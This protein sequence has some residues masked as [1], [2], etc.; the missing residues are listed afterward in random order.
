MADEDQPQEQEKELDPQDAAAAAAVAALAALIA[1]DVTAALAVEDDERRVSLLTALA[2]QSFTLAYEQAG[3]TGSSAEEGRAYTF[4]MRP[5]FGLL[6][7]DG[8]EAQ[9]ER[10]TD[11][12]AH[13]ATTAATMAAANDNAAP[14]EDVAFE[15]RTMQDDRVRDMH[16]PVHGQV[17]AAGE[18]FDVG[19]HSLRYPGQPVGPPEAWINCRCY[20][21]ATVAKTALAAAAPEEHTG[22]AMVAKPANPELIA[23]EGGLPEDE[24]H[25]TLGYFGK[26]DDPNLDPNLRASLEQYLADYPMEPHTARVGGVAFMGD[27]DPQACC[28]LLESEQL[29][30]MRAA[31]ENNYAQPDQKHPHFTPHMTLGYGMDMPEDRPTEIDLDHTEL[32]WGGERMSA[33]DGELVARAF[34]TAQRKGMAD[35]GTAMPDGSYPIAN[36]EDLRNAIQAIGRAK[37]PDAVKRH[38]RKRAAALGAENLIPESWTASGEDLTAADTHDAPGWITNP[39]ETQRLR[40]YWTK[41]AGAAKIRW[42][43][44]GD[45]TRCSKFLG[46]YVGPQ[47]AWGTCNNLHYEVFGK[48]NPEGGRHGSADLDEINAS[49]TAAFAAAKQ[50]ETMPDEITAPPTEWFQDPGFDA[51]TPLTITSDGRVLGHLAAWETCHVGISGDCVTPPKSNTNYAHFRTGEVVTADGS[52]VPVGQI[53]MDTGHAGPN[54]GP[55]DT[56]AHYDNTGTGVADVA[57]GEDDHGIWVAGAM[58]PGVSEQQTYA[59]KA[60]G[61]LSG[62]WRRI[63][64]NLELVAALAVNV[65]GFPIVRTEMAASATGQA[66]ALVAAAVVTLDPNA[67]DADRVAVAVLARLDQRE[68]DKARRARAE[69]LVADVHALRVDALAAAVR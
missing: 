66:L 13:S 2:G 37:D 29:E 59:L 27:D 57:V 39:R 11:I 53:T 31:L 6:E 56:V 5:A 30:Q 42:G 48:F 63:G 8:T 12:I 62:D 24:L 33:Q 43:T 21:A 50:E 18:P 17:R 19:G 34:D 9:Q 10:M 16:R 52:T 41:G 61:A 68:A 65:P 45:L 15:W 51:P 38:I 69:A 46:K 44:P 58:R 1:P 47:Y 36:V 22:I 49:I 20:L 54:A 35:R 7:P 60:T 67:V 3:G 28:L 14:D 23:Q 55:A 32:W 40:N 4:S 64:G 26:T 25:V